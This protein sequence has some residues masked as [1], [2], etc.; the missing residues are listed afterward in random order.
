MC[1]QTRQNQ[2]RDQL[3]S[4]VNRF[5]PGCVIYIS[6]SCSLPLLHRHWFGFV[7]SILNDDRILLLSTLPSQIKTIFRVCH[8]KP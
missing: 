1:V 2:H 7:E 4:Y 6:A 8:K 3:Y 5:G